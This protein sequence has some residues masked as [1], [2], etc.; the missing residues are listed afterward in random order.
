[1][2]PRQRLSSAPQHVQQL[3]ALITFGAAYGHEESK[4]K[5]RHLAGIYGL[6]FYVLTS[7]PATHYPPEIV[8]IVTALPLHGQTG[9]PTKLFLHIRDRD[10][11]RSVWLSS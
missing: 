6:N 1:M 8:M 4:A 11:A 5:R 3:H 2:D 9:I 7:P 10:P